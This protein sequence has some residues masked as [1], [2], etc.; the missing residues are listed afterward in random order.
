[1]AKRKKKAMPTPAITTKR[2]HNP[3][4]QRAHHGERTNPKFITAAINPRESGIVT[5]AA[6]GLIDEAQEEAADRFRGL[7]ETLGGSGAKALDYSREPVDG[8]GRQSE[9]IS[10]R[11]LAAGRD[12]KAV[13][14]AL[15]AEY[16]DYAVALVGRIAGEGHSIH[17]LTQTRRQRDT[18]TDN[19]R[20][21]LDFLAHFWGYSNSAQPS[22]RVV[23]KSV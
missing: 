13:K 14:D 4:Y 18:M 15:Q 12:M 23:R 7:W 9:P 17:E 10:I 16:G 19:L 11:L 6:R 3:L 8:G 1:M 20:T 2:V 22:R 21:Y 5:L